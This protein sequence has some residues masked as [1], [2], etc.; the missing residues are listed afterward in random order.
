MQRK[1]TKLTFLRSFRKYQNFLNQGA[2]KPSMS[3][4][5]WGLADTTGYSLD[6]AN[7]LMPLVSHSSTGF[8]HSRYKAR[9]EGCFSESCFSPTCHDF[10][11][12]IANQ[13][14]SI[15]QQ[16]IQLS[17]GKIRQIDDMSKQASAF[18]C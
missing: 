15:F 11:N 8:E 18:L 9:H 1:S 10:E 6:T 13:Q 3:M 17:F 5:S 2:K 12:R 4:Y 14:T 16:N 7:L